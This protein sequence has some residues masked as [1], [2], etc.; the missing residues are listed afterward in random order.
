MTSPTTSL[1]LWLT[2][3]IC[4]LLFFWLYCSYFFL[5]L[6]SPPIF[7]VSV[8]F[9][10]LCICDPSICPMVIYLLCLSLILSS[11][12][13]TLF[14]ICPGGEYS[15][16]QNLGHPR[17]DIK[18]M[19]EQVSRRPLKMFFFFFFFFSKSLIHFYLTSAFYSSRAELVITTQVCLDPYMDTY[20]H[21]YIHTYIY[22]YIYIHTH[23]HIP[24]VN[25]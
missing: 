8:L 19:A 23:T 3:C 24:M 14:I 4:S 9:A 7:S 25:S 17:L 15:H 21:T 18:R 10:H 20:I 1:S 2:H 22:I 12:K 13:L 6:S 5:W 11:S 16:F